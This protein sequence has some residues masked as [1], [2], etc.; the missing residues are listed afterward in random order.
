MLNDCTLHRDCWSLEVINQKKSFTKIYNVFF[1]DHDSVKRVKNNSVMLTCEL[2]NDLCNIY[3][4]LLSATSIWQMF[5]GVHVHLVKLHCD[6]CLILISQLFQ[7]YFSS[8]S[9]YYR[10][11]LSWCIVFIFQ[12]TSVLVYL[13]SRLSTMKVEA[14]F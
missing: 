5:N 9:M 4:I 11:F 1:A 2:H 13:F 6:L 10:H 8:C 3:L 12:S 7:G 14:E